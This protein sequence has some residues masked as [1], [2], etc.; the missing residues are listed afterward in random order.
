MKC[1]FQKYKRQTLKYLSYKYSDLVVKSHSCCCCCLHLLINIIHNCQ[2]LY[3]NKNEKQKNIKSISRFQRKCS[4][5]WTLL[6]FLRVVKRINAHFSATCIF[7]IHIQLRTGALPVT[8]KHHHQRRPGEPSKP[9]NKMLHKTIL[10]VIIL[11]NFTD[12]LNHLLVEM[13]WKKILP[14]VVYFVWQCINK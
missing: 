7:F 3:V 4:H 2:I 12:L 13:E 6:V 10:Y 5:P 1:L 11:F 8:G 9:G 14:S